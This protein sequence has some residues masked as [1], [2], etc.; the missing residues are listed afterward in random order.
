M[1]TRG[2]L[3]RSGGLQPAGRRQTLADDVGGAGPPFLLPALVCLSP[4]AP[5]PLLAL[6]KSAHGGRIALLATSARSERTTAELMPTFLFFFSFFLCQDT[7]LK[8][9]LYAHS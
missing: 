6:S 2:T 1:L 3:C 8:S 9:H 4:L 5:M 7:F